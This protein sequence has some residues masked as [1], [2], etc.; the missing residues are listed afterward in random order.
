MVHGVHVLY[1]IL[2]IVYTGSCHCAHAHFPFI[3]WSRVQQYEAFCLYVHC[4]E[5][6]TAAHTLTEL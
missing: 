3:P 1:S 6:T 4:E 5:L 2:H